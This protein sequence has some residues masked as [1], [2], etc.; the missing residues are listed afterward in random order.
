[1][2]DIKLNQPLKLS[3][4]FDFQVMLIYK[5]CLPQFLK[6]NAQQLKPVERCFFPLTIFPGNCGNNCSITATKKQSKNKQKTKQKTTQ[7]TFKMYSNVFTSY[8]HE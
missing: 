5:Y 4:I 8:M 6:F 2:W 7:S 3:W 1:M